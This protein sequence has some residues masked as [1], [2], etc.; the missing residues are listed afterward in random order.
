MDT[1]LGRKEAAD[2]LRCSVKTIDRYVMSGK[3]GSYKDGGQV[4]LVRED[5]ELLYKERFR[6]APFST[7]PFHTV[8]DEAVADETTVETP[9]D[10]QDQDISFEPL[11][12]PEAALLQ[13][14][15]EPAQQ[16]SSE[17]VMSSGADQQ[18]DA[19][20]AA[21]DKNNKETVSYYREL[22]TDLRTELKEKQ[23]RLE[24]ANYKI[25]E[26]QSELAS[27]IPLLEYRAKD[28]EIFALRLEKQQAEIAFRQK[29]SQVEM[30]LQQERMNKYVYAG[31]VFFIGILA[32]LVFL[33]HFG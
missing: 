21:I 23:T 2:M 18:Y 27:R 32:A 6:T 11:E 20:F 14:T 7:V 3:I 33:F 16:D 9:E 28:E 13:K 10:W 5:V 4:R 24:A 12:Q 29:M 25:G 26:M 22:I 19:F 17:E 30:V 1:S 31:L 15:V 8:L